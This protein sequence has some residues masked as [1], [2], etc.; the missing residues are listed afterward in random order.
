MAKEMGTSAHETEFRR[1]ISES[2]GA[3]FL[4]LAPEGEEADDVEVAMLH[5]LL[6]C[7]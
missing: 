1:E 5:L 3:L 4:E 6:L 7:P 2:V